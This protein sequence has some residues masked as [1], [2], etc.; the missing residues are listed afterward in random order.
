VLF[1]S[2]PLTPCINGNV[3]DPYAPFDP[4]AEHL[5]FAIAPFVDAQGTYS[6]FRKK[7]DVN[8]FQAGVD[9]QA[10]IRGGAVFDSQYFVL[11]PY[12]QTDFAGIAN[13][14]GVRAGWEPV[15]PDLHLGGRI[16][17]PNPYLDWFWQL[18]AEVDAKDVTNVGSTALTKSNYYWGGGT[19]QAHFKLFPGRSDTEPGWMAPA[20]LLVDRIYFNTTLH[21]FWNMNTGRSV[22]LFEGEV[23]YNLSPD[24]KSSISLKYDNGIDKDIMKNA[25][26]Y[27]MALNFKY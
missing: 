22:S 23:G 27:L 8:N 18:Q 14:Y 20:P 5:G 1:S 21:F 11:T 26:T 16:G 17:V 9:V 12:Y 7:G 2:D 10:Q 4:F 13:I 15:A 24:G 3:G 25:Q 19:V 6:G